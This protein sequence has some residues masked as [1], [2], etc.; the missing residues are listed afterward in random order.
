MKGFLIFLTGVFLLLGA[1]GYYMLTHQ[2]PN[3]TVV[4]MNGKWVVIEK[5]HDEADQKGMKAQ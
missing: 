5:E 3:S 4:R 2:D 1:V